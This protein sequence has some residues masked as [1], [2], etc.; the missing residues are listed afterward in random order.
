MFSHNIIRSICSKVREAG[1]FA[2][3]VDGTQ[4]IS[5]N[6]QE[7]ICIRYVDEKLNVVEA[8]IGLYDSSSST[9]G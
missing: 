9:T 1:A 7:S 3:I 8:F 6:E 2:T 5:G 4:D